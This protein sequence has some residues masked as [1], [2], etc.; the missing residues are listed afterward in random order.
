MVV[1]GVLIGDHWDIVFVARPSAAAVA[2]DWPWLLVAAT[3]FAG[4]GLCCLASVAFIPVGL[5][6]LLF[7]PGRWRSR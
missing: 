3:A 4:Q 7:S 1:R 5:A 6:A 2:G